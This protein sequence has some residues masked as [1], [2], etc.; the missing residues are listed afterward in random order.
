M[1]SSPAPINV[2][3]SSSKVIGTTLGSRSNMYP[4]HNALIP[5]TNPSTS[6]DIG[7]NDVSTKKQNEKMTKSFSFSSIFSFMFLEFS[8]TPKRGARNSIVLS[9]SNFFPFSSSC[10]GKLAKIIGLGWRSHPH[11]KSWSHHFSY[12]QDQNRSVPKI[13]FRKNASQ[14]HTINLIGKSTMQRKREIINL[15]GRNHQI[16]EMSNILQLI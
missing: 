6:R 7:P 1:L 5:C 4:S 9:R 10:R 3:T 12:Y 14:R 11:R 2:L 16:T 13:L 8:G 15:I